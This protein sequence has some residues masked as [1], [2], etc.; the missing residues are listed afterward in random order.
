MQDAL[1]GQSGSTPNNEVRT[2]I[3]A[4]GQG[5][6]AVM[7][8]GNAVGQED[9]ARRQECHVMEQRG[10]AISQGHHAIAQWGHAIEQES[11]AVGQGCC[12]MEQEGRA[13]EQGRHAI[14][15]EGHAMGQWGSCCGERGFQGPGPHCGSLMAW[16]KPSRWDLALHG[17]KQ[18]LDQA[19][20][21]PC[22]EPS[23]QP[24]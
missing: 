19:G 7:K 18:W 6:H 23:Q 9:H 14:G 20:I 17:W 5:D 12:A 3:Y 11:H 24:A 2:A 21:C 10:Y 8:E 16:S 22:I 1:G 15:Q 4:T 13:I